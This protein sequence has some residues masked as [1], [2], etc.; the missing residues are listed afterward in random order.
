MRSKLCAREHGV[1]G[2]AETH[3]HIVEP[4]ALDPLTEG[5]TRF[6]DYIF[7]QYPA[8]SADRRARRTE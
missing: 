1:V 6:L 2:L 3:G 8:A 7:G 5:H 4:F